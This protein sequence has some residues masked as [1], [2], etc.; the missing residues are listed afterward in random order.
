MPTPTVLNAQPPWDGP[1][2]DAGELGTRLQ[3]IVLS[4]QGTF[5]AEDGAHLT[6]A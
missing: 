2:T 3:K 6:A 4:L 1:A 5:F